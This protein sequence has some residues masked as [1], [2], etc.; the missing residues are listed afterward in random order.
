[1]ENTEKGEKWGKWKF[2]RTAWEIETSNEFRV[3]ETGKI[4]LLKQKEDGMENRR[5][6]REMGNGKKNDSLW[7]LTVENQ[8]IL[9]FHSK[10]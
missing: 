9:K 10:I 1:M 3:L 2:G 5:K 4:S 7:E 8:S 6:K